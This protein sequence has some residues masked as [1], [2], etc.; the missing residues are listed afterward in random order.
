ME[1]IEGQIAPGAVGKASDHMNDSRGAAIAAKAHPGEGGYYRWAEPNSD[2]TVCLKTET[3]DRLQIDALRGIAASPRDGKEVGG[4]LLGRT[5]TTEGAACTFVDDFVPFPCSHRNGPFYDLT[6]AEAAGFAAALE[7]GRAHWEQSV[8]GYYRSH[9][10]DGL[11][12]SSGDLQLIQRHF[13]AS[14]NIFLIV[15]TL[16]NRACTAGFFFWK[17]GRIQSEFTDSEAPLIPVSLPAA[18]ESPV[19]PQVVAQALRDPLVASATEL[20]R[21]RTV[22]RRLIRGIAIA[23]VAA[24]A[25]VAVIRYREPQPVRNKPTADSPRVANSIVAATAEIPKPISNPE[26]LGPAAAPPEKKA[27]SAEAQPAATRPAD[28]GP[29][30]SSPVPETAVASPRPAAEPLSLPVEKAAAEKTPAEK[31]ASEK[32]PDATAAPPLNGAPPVPA[33]PPIAVPPPS[34]PSSPTAATQ[35]P[36]TGAPLTPTTGAL[37]TLKTGAPPAAS[38]EIASSS[39]SV[40]SPVRTRVGPQVIHQA[41]P[42]VPRGVGPKIT[43]DV[44]LD[45]EVG[46][47][48][49]GKVTRARIVSTKGAAA[50]LLAIETLKAAQSFRFKPA[51]ENGATVASVMVLTFRFDQLAK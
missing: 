2:I 50:G 45:V 43:S 33:G 48:V 12:L 8:V 4:I 18:I 30:I 1:P 29:S 19:G 24:A 23:G 9:N 6:A 3:V 39:P 42:A 38:E 44:E 37:A 21:R 22:R 36:T 32:V 7:R 13:P 14:D 34:A 51:Q 27:A 35:R 46:I 40:P 49:K 20:T 41:T 17:D 25:T 26:P 11:F 47:D 28:P 16:P 5:E 31:T 10:R 15:K